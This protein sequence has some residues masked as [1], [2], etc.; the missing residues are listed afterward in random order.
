MRHICSLVIFLFLISSSYAHATPAKYYVPPTQFNV[1][2]QVAGENVPAATGLFQSAIGSFVYDT[3]TKTLSHLRL[4]ID[5]QSLMAQSAAT[6]KSLQVLFEA[7]QF[8]EITFSATGPIE[9]KEDHG[10]VKGTLSVH[11]QSKSV[12][13]DGSLSV[14]DTEV[15]GGGTQSASLSLRGSFKRADFGMAGGMD[16]AAPSFGD[17]LTLMMETQGVRQ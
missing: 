1:A 16:A 14:N 9:F 4:A 10:E 15:T 17:T 3:D 5:A 11:G 8:P 12:T 7:K 6:A 2:F 13:L